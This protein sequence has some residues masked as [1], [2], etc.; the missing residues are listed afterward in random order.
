[1]FGFFSTYFELHPA[2]SAKLVALAET[3]AP[4]ILGAAVAADLEMSHEIYVDV[5]D[6]SLFNFGEEHV[7]IALEYCNALR[8][9]EA[10]SSYK[11][12]TVHVYR[13]NVPY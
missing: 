9:T 3:H 12:L 6:P 13:D 10:P 7:D 4:E 1:M 2:A 5:D 11:L 8:P